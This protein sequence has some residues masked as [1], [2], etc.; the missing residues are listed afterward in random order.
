VEN[1][2]YYKKRAI[3]L[4][5]FGGAGYLVFGTFISLLSFYIG[6]NTEENLQTPWNVSHLIGFITILLIFFP[7]ALR[8]YHLA[9]KAELK[10]M[11]RITFC[12]VV[13]MALNLL[14]VF[15]IWLFS[16]T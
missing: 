5:K 14:V 8:V 2:A 3:R 4:A 7:I 10:W 13:F 15:L 1:N 16:R 12:I 9:K 11:R 6:A